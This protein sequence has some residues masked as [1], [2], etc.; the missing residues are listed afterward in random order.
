MEY[1]VNIAR[2]PPFEFDAPFRIQRQSAAIA[3]PGNDDRMK[4]INVC[5]AICELEKICRSIR[6]DKHVVS[7]G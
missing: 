4:K 1:S 3:R 2:F 6:A 7:A 5:A